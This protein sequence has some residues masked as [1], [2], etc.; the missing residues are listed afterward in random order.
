MPKTYAESGDIVSASDLLNRWIG[1][2]EDEL[3][4]LIEVGTLNVYQLAMTH[5]NPT[6]GLVHSCSPTSAPILHVYRTRKAYGWDGL[7]FFPVDVERVEQSNPKFM[8]ERLGPRTPQMTAEDL[9]ESAK[10]YTR[11]DTLAKLY[12]MD[13]SDLLCILGPARGQLHYDS[14]DGVSYPLGLSDLANVYINNYSLLR[15]RTRYKVKFLKLSNRREVEAHNFVGENMSDIEDTK[16]LI[17]QLRSENKSLLAENAA[18]KSATK[19]NTIAPGPKKTA[20]ATAGKEE[21][22][23]TDWAA[24]LRMAV[25]LAVE[26]AQ[27]GKPKSTTRHLAMWNKLWD[28]PEGSGYRREAFREFRLGLPT[29]LKGDKN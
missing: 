5:R 19:K 28:K 10:S 22:T 24:S 3:A 20:N 16:S 14:D 1:I 26:C 18:L 25:S 13:P 12:G 27:S 21:K 2:T 15:W 4:K 29:S 11:A 7:V 17:A 6:G 23:A 8:L 9:A